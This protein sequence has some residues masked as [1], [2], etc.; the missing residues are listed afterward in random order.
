MA[1]KK[2]CCANC[3]NDIGLEKQ[4]IPT[5]SKRAGTCSFCK[6]KNTIVVDPAD[7]KDSFEQLMEIYDESEKGK[8][9]IECL[10]N[11]WG[12]F[13]RQNMEYYKSCELMAVILDD[14]EIDKKRFIPSKLCHSDSLDLWKKFKQ[15]I[16]TTNR[17]F[18][19]N[20]LNEDLLSSLLPQLT[21]NLNEITKEW[22][23][24]RI[25]RG[26]NKFSRNEMG[27]PPPELASQGRANPTG[28]PYLY[29]ASDL[30][31]AISEIRPHTGNQI[32]VAKISILDSLDVIDLRDPR[33][34][35]SPF[36]VN[37]DKDLASLRG[38]IEFLVD[39]GE[40][41]K[42]P[43]LPHAADLDY[44]PSQYLCEFIKN[45]KYHGVLYKSS[46]GDGVNLA[47]FDPN[48]G[49]IG[50]IE[51]RLVSKVQIQLE[52]EM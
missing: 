9:L 11:D 47:L 27:A 43:V 36:D 15:E 13:T 32:C 33:S 42:R 4:V 14:N 35:I 20:K 34:T 19:T 30:N 49:K 3:F 18:P 7:L 25:Q 51:Q 6:N 45:Q 40:D 26:K 16:R 44:L 5:F 52:N 46:V 28:I 2:K 48:L 1:R 39:L 23:R 41:L 10:K 24:A 22:F 37:E 21:I 29:I 17:F 38:D 31:T 12:M 50:K 8:P